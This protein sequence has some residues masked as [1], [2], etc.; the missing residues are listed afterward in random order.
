MDSQNGPKQENNYL[1]LRK[2]I[3]MDDYDDL[4]TLLTSLKNTDEIQWYT[5]QGSYASPEMCIV[6]DTQHV[7]ELTPEVMYKIL[8]YGYYVSRLFTYPERSEVKLFLRKVK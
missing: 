2:A 1:V 4:E 8:Q 7:K 5:N 6:I 3:E